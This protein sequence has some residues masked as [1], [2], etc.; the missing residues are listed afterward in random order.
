M[1]IT[2]RK[3]PKENFRDFEEMEASTNSSLITYLVDAGRIFRVSI[4]AYVVKI[5]SAQK[6]KL[7]DYCLLSQLAK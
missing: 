6:Y 7:S 3:V 1:S 4:I 5:I 2:I